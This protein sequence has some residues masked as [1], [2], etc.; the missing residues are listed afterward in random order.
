M[1]GVD[2]RHRL[3]LATNVQVH[4]MLANAPQYLSEH[5]VDAI[6]SFLTRKA[7]DVVVRS[8]EDFKLESKPKL[9]GKI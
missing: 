9:K 8:V 4:G 2:E 6:S 3:P 1:C 7:S 5:S